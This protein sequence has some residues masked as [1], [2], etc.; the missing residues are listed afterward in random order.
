MQSRMCKCSKKWIVSPDG[1][2]DEDVLVA[3]DRRAVEDQNSRD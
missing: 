1:D 2:V 3:V